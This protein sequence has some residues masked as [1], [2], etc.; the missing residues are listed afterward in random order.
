MASSKQVGGNSTAA[1]WQA[2]QVACT[3]A[4]SL[5]LGPGEARP[6]ALRGG[7]KAWSRRVCPRGVSCADQVK[8]EWHSC[9]D[10]IPEQSGGAQAA[11]PVCRPYSKQLTQAAGLPPQRRAHRLLQ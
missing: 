4:N 10:T 5:E 6:G 8:A 2:Q 9:K 7:N 3:T 1:P 11:C